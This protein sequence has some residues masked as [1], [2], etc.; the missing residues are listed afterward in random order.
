M[1]DQRSPS[2]DRGRGRGARCEVTIEKIVAG[3]HGLARVDGTSAGEVVLVPRVAIGE[4]VAV[5]LD[6]TKKPARG[7]LLKVLE[8][9]VDRVEPRCPIVDRCGACDLMHLQPSAQR[10]A[11]EE[12]ISAALPT[13]LREMHI[14]LHEATPAR[15][16]TRARWHVRS[17]GEGDR[18]RAV[19]GY[20]A[21][22]TQV[23]VDVETCAVLDP[24][25]DAAL[26]H[27]RAM[28][29]SARGEGEVHAALGAGGNPV[30][31][32]VWKGELPGATYRLAEELVSTGALAGLQV[33]LEGARIPATIGDP[34]PLVI[35]EDGLPLMSPP[36]GFAQASEVGDAVLVRL[37]VERAAARDANVVELFSG[38]GNFTVA[39]ARDAAHVTAIELVDSACRAA[40]ENLAARAL[41]GKVKVV[42]GD[43]DQSAL[44]P[45]TDV[46]VL[47]PPRAGAP[48]AM[49]AILARKP[50]RVV[51]VSCDPPTLGRDLGKLVEGG[52][53]VGSID[54]VDLF[55]E[56]SHVEVVVTLHKARR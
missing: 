56:T 40:R 21:A 39:L 27:L 45:N 10:R 26:G 36:Q 9:S 35:A 25:L 52:Y 11:R 3:G 48:G 12:I 44:P 42:Q 20:R 15:G 29:A 1:A 22:G 38:S 43:A 16:R 13:S 54:A 28:L 47:D 53:V 18:S 6:R 4:R 46:V 32:I 50:K 30:L 17:I 31:S 55:P 51:Y 2:P 41:S 49:T 14:E 23:V 7:R 37:V 24:R 34:R 33:Q 8:R 19:V 5:E